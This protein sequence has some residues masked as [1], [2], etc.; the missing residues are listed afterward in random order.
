M[1]WLYA[2]VGRSGEIEVANGY[3]KID[4]RVAHKGEEGGGFDAA[5]GV[6]RE[7]KLLL[8]DGGGCQLHG[9]HGLDKPLGRV[10]RGIAQ[11]GYAFGFALRTRVDAVAKA[12][13]AANFVSVGSAK[14][15]TIARVRESNP[16]AVQPQSLQGQHQLLALNAAKA[17]GLVALGG[18][19]YDV[20]M[21]VFKLSIGK[22]VFK[23][24]R[25]IGDHAEREAILVVDALNFG[26]YALHHLRTY[27]PGEIL[28]HGMAAG[29][30]RQEF[31]IGWKSHFTRSGF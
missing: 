5:I 14:H 4:L 28:A 9:L 11:L 7:V 30:G 24:A 27:R 17:C 3:A 26:I 15:I 19:Y 8:I 31:V 16:A 25:L 29:N 6:E 18:R 10:G 13:N 1:W 22:D 20:V 23:R 21:R 2:A 12:D